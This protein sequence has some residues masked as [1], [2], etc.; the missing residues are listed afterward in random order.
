MKF[1][2]VDIAREYMRDALSEDEGLRHGYVANIA[3][4]LRDR[5]GINPHKGDP[6]WDEQADIRAANEIIDL[7]Y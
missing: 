4:L 2:S 7:V 6:L 1:V 3:A 5:Y